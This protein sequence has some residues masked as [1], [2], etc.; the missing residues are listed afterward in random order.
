MEGAVWIHFG[1]LISCDQIGES[2]S[3][4]FQ[5]SVEKVIGFKTAYTTTFK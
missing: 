1:F 5:V 4:A 3:T 2:D